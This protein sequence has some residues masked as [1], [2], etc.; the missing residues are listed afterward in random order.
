[1]EAQYGENEIRKI[2]IQKAFD[3]KLG[4]TRFLMDRFNEVFKST[5]HK[6]EIKQ[7]LIIFLENR[8]KDI[9]DTLR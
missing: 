7:L 4:K 6:K 3:K 2:L 8:D 5:S 1:M 9:S